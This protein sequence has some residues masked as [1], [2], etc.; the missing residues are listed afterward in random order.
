MKISVSLCLAVCAMLSA[1]VSGPKPETKQEVSTGP[2]SGVKA[3]PVG[4]NWAQIAWTTRQ[5]ADTV[6]EY[7]ETTNYGSTANEDTLWT[8]HRI[9]LFDL[10]PMTE[11][12][13]RVRGTNA[14]KESFTSGDGTFKTGAV[15]YG[16]E[17]N[18]TGEPLG[19]GLGYSKTIKREQATVVVKNAEEFLKA[20]G[21][22][23]KG[24]IIYIEDKAVIDLSN[25]PRL[26][27]AI[28]GGIAIASGRGQSGS[29]GGLIQYTTFT[30]GASTPLFRTGGPGIRITGV[31]FGG[32]SNG[33]GRTGPMYHLLYVAHYWTEVD[34]CEF[35]GWNY[36][37]VETVANADGRGLY[38][39][40]NYFHHNTRLG[41]GY[42]VCSSM[43][44]ALVEGNLFDFH[45]HSIASSAWAPSSY[46]ARYNLVME[47]S[48]SH[49]FDMHGAVDSEV[50]TNVG[51]WRFDEGKGSATKDTSTYGHNDPKMH[52]FTEANWIPGEANTALQFNGKS[53][54]D[55]TPGYRNNLGDQSFCVMAWIKPDK[56]E[57]TQTVFSKAPTTSKGEGYSLRLVGPA[58][59][60]TV[61]DGT[62]A[63]Q[64]RTS[65]AVAAG[66][67]NHM[68]LSFNGSLARV[69]VN[70][71]QTAS[72]EC[73]GV[74]AS[75][76][77]SFAIGRDS[78][79]ATAYFKGGIDEVRAYRAAM[80][81]ADVN[82]NYIGQG[83]IAG[84]YMR[85]HHN[86][87]R[88]LN[89]GG[90]CVR[91]RPAE[92][93]WINN[94]WFYRANDDW[95]IRQLNVTGN[96]FEKDNLFGPRKEKPAGRAPTLSWAG[97]KE[98]KKGG[99]APQ[100]G[101]SGEIYRFEVKYTDPDNDAPL[102]GYPRLVLKRKGEIFLYDTPM[103]M[104]PLDGKKFS[105]GRTYM[106]EIAL[107]RGTDYTYSFEALDMAG[108]KAV[109]DATKDAAGPVIT[110][111]NAAPVLYPVMGHE[112]YV[113]NWIFPS[114][115][116]VD[117]E[118]DFR[119][120]YLDIDND[121]PEGGAPKARITDGNGGD[122]AGSPFPM[123]PITR[124][125]D[126]NGRDY[127]LLT[128][129][130]V[131]EFR[132][133]IVAKDSQGAAARNVRPSNVTVRPAGSATALTP[134]TPFE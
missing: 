66:K 83:D 94:N 46:E 10:K 24:D 34:N 14:A 65:G 98:F 39:H 110:G 89:Q 75:P 2:I 113:E 8:G 107:P 67:W 47:H 76:G 5:D 87:S 13:Y 19:G 3:F 132:C 85:I 69:Y 20:L 56:V 123:K 115:G 122:I 59:E 100:N 125:Q 1:C 43:G 68:A 44:V 128:K 21:S 90:V 103:T 121:A 9:T 104:M 17:S 71:K 96:F 81:P 127:Q 40:H 95:N 106:C 49:A 130:P 64:S 48:I 45:R 118:F 37:V 109:G 36:S 27:I 38:V 50:R 79:T 51:I 54:V 105:K 99:V 70:G 102:P 58:V 16:T 80:T 133:E 26:D 57:G 42:A 73:K 31:R 55:C 86:T 12:H 92:G 35:W 60:A 63:K 4:D 119:V 82:R 120:T 111:G 22:A 84:V 28:P 74:K 41:C 18:P 134:R 88:I 29:V 114:N 101:K 124:T 131:G 62:G 6:V 52:G 116:T 78:V 77:R 126:A 117:T 108:N 112:N 23:K 97:V 93:C 25:V 7:G 30:S 61:Y 53:W 15:V 11:Y 72:F 33:P 129:L 32:P 91:G